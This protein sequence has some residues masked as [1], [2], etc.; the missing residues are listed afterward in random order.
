M[1]E[2]GRT[3]GFAVVMLVVLGA[4]SGAGAQEPPITEVSRDQYDAWMTDLSNWG[5]W[6]ADDQIGALNVITDGKR[7]E[8]A[9]LVEPGTVVAMARDRPG[10]HSD[11]G[12]TP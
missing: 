3:V 8:A 11:A 6:G 4:W 1:R 5:R 2:R 10:D 9:R 12:R 7:V